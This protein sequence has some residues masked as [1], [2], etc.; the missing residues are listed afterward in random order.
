MIDASEIINLSKYTK[1]RH[2]VRR[3]S[4]SHNRDSYR[5]IYTLLLVKIQRINNAKVLSSG[6]N[7]TSMKINEIDGPE[8]M[9][10]RS[11]ANKKKNNNDN[12]K[13][14]RSI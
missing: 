2:S 10:F 14:V 7:T 5:R 6:N 4:V 12:I 3:K 13:N 11:F 9:A 8:M 1:N